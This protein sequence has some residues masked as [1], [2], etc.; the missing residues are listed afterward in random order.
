MHVKYIVLIAVMF[1]ASLSVH[2][3]Q[4]QS[5]VHVRSLATVRRETESSDDQIAV[6]YQRLVTAA[7]SKRQV[8]SAYLRRIDKHIMKLERQ[9]LFLQREKIKKEIAQGEKL[10]KDIE[11]RLQLCKK[12][13]F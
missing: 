12:I 13:G 6:N 9:L 3:G 5:H 8:T 11:V 7:L 4:V 10:V 2:A 1:G